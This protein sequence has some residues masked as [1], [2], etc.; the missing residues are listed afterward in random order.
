[1]LLISTHILDLFRKLPTSHMWENGMDI[2]SEYETSY[3]TQYQEAFLKDVDNEYCVKH[4][5]GPVNNL[6]MVP[7]SN[8]VASSMDLGSY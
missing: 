8:L 1:M 6:E 2:D 3:I 7:S 5:C 4:Q